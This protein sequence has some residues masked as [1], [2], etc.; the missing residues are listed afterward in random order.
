MG[1]IFEEVVFQ[2]DCFAGELDRPPERSFFAA[3]AHFRHPEVKEIHDAVFS[4]E[5]RDRALT[6]KI[7]RLAKTLKEPSLPS[8]KSPIWNCSFPRM[9]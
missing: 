8:S 9:P 2:T 4:S 6:Q 5:A 7:H 1:G 3:E